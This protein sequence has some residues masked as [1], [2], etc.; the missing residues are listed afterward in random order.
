MA[1]Q[2][3]V[4]DGLGPQLIRLT[5]ICMMSRILFIIL[6]V[7]LVSPRPIE[8]SKDGVKLSG[9]FRSRGEFDASDFNNDTPAHRSTLLRIRLNAAFQPAE[10]ISTFVQLQDSRVYGAEPN[11]FAN[12]HNVDLHQAYLQVDEFFAKKLTLKMGRM[13]MAYAEERLIGSVDWHNVGRAF[14]GTLLRYAPSEMS[15]LDVFGTKI[16]QRAG[17]ENPADTGFY[18]GGLY[19]SHQPKESYRV[20]L[21][22]L[23]ELNRR[24]TVSRGADLQR[25]TIGTYDT[26]EF[27]A[28]DYEIEAAVQF[29]TR[30]NTSTG[31]RQ[32]VSAFMLTG[33]LGYTVDI[34]HK[35][36]IVLGYDYLSGG[37]PADENYKAFDT[38]FATNHKFYG[39]MDYFV[40]IP[41]HTEGR[42]LQD[43]MVKC[44]IAPHKKL[45]VR[46]DVHQFMLAK[47]MMDDNSYGR[48]VDLTVLYRYHEVLRFEFG[49]SLFM[50]DKL[51]QTRFRGHGDRAFWAYLMT[52]ANF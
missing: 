16:V 12:F 7:A 35:P 44:Q 26:G 5:E 8:S 32:R 22:I 47:R 4:R 18:F 21:Y 39:F 1:H 36:R 28:V 38:S 48:E 14:D 34:D 2:T 9:Q 3:P 42:G 24:E 40:N 29:G 41:V 37:E 20:D 11:T 15:T 33:A 49:A 45:T 43:L 23:G 27:N 10:K 31:E 50:P 46:A 19:A 30:H 17:S 52:T 51:M 13:Q 6:I 25:V